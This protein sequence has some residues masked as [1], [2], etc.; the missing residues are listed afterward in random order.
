MLLPR[1]IL[2]LLT[3]LSSGL[4]W[5]V[6]LI[7]ASGVSSKPWALILATGTSLLL[8]LM[9]VWHVRDYRRHTRKLLFLLEAIENNDTSIRFTEPGRHDKEPE[10]SV[11]EALNRLAT[12]LHR[13]KQQ[14]AQQEKYYELILECAGSGILVINRRGDICQKNS[15]ALRLLS[16]E[17]LTHLDQ[18]NRISPPLSQQ[19]HNCCGGDILQ[20]SYSNRQGEVTLAIHVRQIILGEEELR[21]IALNDI[22]NELDQQELDAWVRLTRVLIH[23][24]MNAITPITSISDTLLQL[25]HHDDMPADGSSTHSSSSSPLPD[26]VKQGLQTISHT[27]ESLMH[28]VESY[29]RFTSLPTPSPEVFGLQEF[30]QRMVHLARHQYAAEEIQFLVEVQPDDL[31]LYADEKLISQVLTNLLKNAIQAIGEQ[32][33]SAGTPS[34]QLMEQSTG[35]IRI[36]AY[37][38]EAEAVVIEVSNSGPQIPAETAAHIFIPFFS[39]KP[40]GSG[41]GLSISRQIMRLSGGHLRLLPGT[42]TTF[43]LTFD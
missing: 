32:K 10:H 26:E 9:V 18:L 30:L 6:W 4:L 35:H 20:A 42:P 17:V 8:P 15:E 41:I 1:L 25:S 23:E 29:R 40:Q 3:S 33:A 7:H 14:T 19:L 43:Q 5:A 22:R 11:N 34:A 16:M 13:I 31:L 12:M 24:I 37:S 21:I 2:L 28:F 39:T 38:N 36:H 27:G